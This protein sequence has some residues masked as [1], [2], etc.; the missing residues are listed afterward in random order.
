MCNLAETGQRGRSTLLAG[1]THGR[2][3]PYHVCTARI[4]HR[5]ASNSKL[6]WN[7]GAA[8]SFGLQ[9]RE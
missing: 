8:W 7:Y 2:S 9:M 1:K 5:L 3:T 6:D 4:S